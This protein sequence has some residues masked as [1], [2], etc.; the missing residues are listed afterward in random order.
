M[1]REPGLDALDGAGSPDAAGMDGVGSAAAAV[2]AAAAALEDAVT[3]RDFPRIG[4]ANASL[5]DALCTLERALAAAS[6]PATSRAALRARLSPLLARHERLTGT[7]IEL[8][9]AARD[10]LA[11][12]RESHRSAARYLESSE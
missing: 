1:P 12:A 4:M 5:H 8:R 3:A 9:D 10:E 2:E 7:L 6:A 11:K